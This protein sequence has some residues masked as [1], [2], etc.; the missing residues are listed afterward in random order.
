MAAG[1]GVMVIAAGPT[2]MAVP[3]TEQL[4]GGCWV[5]GAAIAGSLGTVLAA[6]AI[7]V[8]SR[9]RVPVVLRWMLW[10][11]GMLAGWMLVPVFA[12]MVLVTQFVAGLSQAAFEGDMDAR[13]AG[14]SRPGSV[15]RDLAFAASAR[16]LGAA[17]SVRVLPVVVAPAEVGMFAGTAVFVLVI[18]VGAWL[19]AVLL[20]RRRSLAGHA[21]GQPLI[22][23]VLEA[24]PHERPIPG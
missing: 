9:V 4:Y 24:V 20:R 13:V 15:T 18:V 10:G 7:A 21:V 12:P 22:A 2:L 23:S 19:V 14:D 16:A 3:L 8:M 5:A 6:R 17:I 11:L 1:A